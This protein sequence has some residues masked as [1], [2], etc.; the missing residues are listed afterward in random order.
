[1]TGS[2]AGK[3]NDRYEGAGYQTPVAAG[4]LDNFTHLL[5]GHGTALDAA[6][7]RGGNAV[8]LARHGLDTQAWDI[9]SAALQLVKQAAIEAKVHIKTRERDISL[10]PP[11][12]GSFDVI[13]ISRFLDRNLAKPLSAALKP[14]GLIFYQTFTRDKVDTTGP[15]NPDYLLM[16]N[17]L[18]QMFADL[19]IVYYHEEGTRGDT[20]T[21][22]RNEAQLIVRKP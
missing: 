15:G 4:V 7:G 1:M 9:S 16:T 13:C 6:C 5:P 12:P 8:V 3:W 18:L 20:N 17:E 10:Q 2:D 19:V 14:G 11:D 21:G 22:F